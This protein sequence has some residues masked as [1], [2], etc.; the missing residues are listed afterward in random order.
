M[1][2]KIFRSS[3]LITLFILITS[4][5][6]I[7]GILYDYF[8]S[9]LINELKREAGY[10]SIAIEN[11]G[12]DYLSGINDKNERITLIAPDGTVIADTVADAESLENHGSRDEVK[13]AIQNGS[14]TSLRYSNTL[15]KRI[16]Y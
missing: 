14:G 9:Q 6:L 5:A 12:L 2:K 1:H 16:V 4:V 3:V 7:M 13:L 10:I 15:T 8:E 11:E